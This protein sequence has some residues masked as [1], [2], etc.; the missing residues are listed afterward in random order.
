MPS[1][2]SAPE[3]LQIQHQP[4][5]ILDDLL[6][7]HQEGD[8]LAAVDDAVIVGEREIHHRPR[9]DL[10]AHHHR[11]FL[12]L[13][14]AEDAGLRRVEDRRRHQRAVDAAIGDGEGAA[15]H[16][17]DLERALTRAAAQIGDL[18]L[19]V[20]EQF[21]IAVAHHRNDEAFVGPDRD[22]DRLSIAGI[23]TAIA[24]LGRR[25][26][27]GKLSIDEL[28]G[29]TF[30]ITNGG[31]YGSLMSTPILNAPQ[32]GILGMHRIEDRPVVRGGAVVVRPMMYL[33]L[34]YDH[35]IV[36]GKEAVT[37]LVRVKEALEDPTRL[38][39]DL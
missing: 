2:P 9:L 11:P 6:D 22:A 33:A 27:D 37:F 35:R 24:D 18:L 36:D 14:H 5:R 16:L 1:R 30:T 21:P 15:L 3:G 23:E 7:A 32:S 4:G 17:L 29:G 20:G 8:R 31:I 38:V 25:A 28:Q 34:S 19:D 26:R 10:A 13:V 39:L 12:D